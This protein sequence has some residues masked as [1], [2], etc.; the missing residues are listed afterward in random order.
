MNTT[1]TAMTYRGGLLASEADTLMRKLERED[2]QLRKLGGSGNYEKVYA[3]F[4]NEIQ[5]KKYYR[6]MVVAR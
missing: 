2:I 5:D 4:Q 1:K 6:V 3:E